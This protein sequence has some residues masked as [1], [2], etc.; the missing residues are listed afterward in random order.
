MIGIR[1]LEKLG[2]FEG[3]EGFI[4]DTRWLRGV[5]IRV[6]EKLDK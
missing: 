4:S 6:L 2:I 5:I 1:L 3:T